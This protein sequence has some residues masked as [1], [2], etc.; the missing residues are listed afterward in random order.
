MMSEENRDFL[1]AQTGKNSDAVDRAAMLVAAA[2]GL[3]CI[4]FPL[5]L[6]ITTASGILN[7]ASRPLEIGFIACAFV[8]GAAN[9]SFSWW[10]S[11]HRP[12]CLL[13]F[14]AGMGMILIHDHFSGVFVSTAV[15]VSGGAIVAAAHYRNLKLVKSCRCCDSGSQCPA[16]R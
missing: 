10:R 13:L 14:A 11:H 4:C 15:S 5:L 3:H 2:C 16:S 9:L 6:A 1:S 7:R 12:E 8:L